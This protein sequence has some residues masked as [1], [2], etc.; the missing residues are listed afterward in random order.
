MTRAWKS[1]TGARAPRPPCPPPAGPAALLPLRGDLTRAGPALAL[2][3]PVVGA[4]IV[5]GRPPALVTA[6]ALAG[7]LAGLEAP[8]YVAPIDVMRAVAGFNIHRGAVA[9]ASRLPLPEASSLLAGARRV[10]QPE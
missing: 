2:V 3:L 7:S 6:V 10:A 5:G 9:S 8:V 4:G 1:A